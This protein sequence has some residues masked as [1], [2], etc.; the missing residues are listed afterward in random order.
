MNITLRHCDLGRRIVAASTVTLLLAGCQSP[1]PPTDPVAALAAPQQVA[2][3]AAEASAIQPFSYLQ[4]V[5]A[6]AVGVVVFGEVVSPW[7]IVGGGIVIGAGLFAFWRERV[8][9][10]AARGP[11]GR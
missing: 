11:S 10:K 3:K 9:A 1:A 7:T 5:F 2:T 8:R 4:T 6:S